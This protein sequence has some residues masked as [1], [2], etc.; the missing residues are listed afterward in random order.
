MQN[1]NTPTVYGPKTQQVNSDLAVCKLRNM[2]ARLIT[3]N[4]RDDET[5]DQCGFQVIPGG[6]FGDTLATAS[7]MNAPLTK[8]LIESG[9]LISLPL[10]HGE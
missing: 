1:F 7:V 10:D 4:V 6:A 8:H 3:I 5:G 2:A 9:D